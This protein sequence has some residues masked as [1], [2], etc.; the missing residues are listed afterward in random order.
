[1]GP[2]LTNRRPPPDGRMT[3]ARAVTGY[4]IFLLLCTS[5]AAVWLAVRVRG[6]HKALVDLHNNERER[7]FDLSLDMMCVA[8]FDGSVK[9]ANPQFAIATGWSPEEVLTDDF[10]QFIHPEDRELSAKLMM[11]AM[12]GEPLVNFRNRVRCKDGSYKLLAWKIAPDVK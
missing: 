8:G 3:A 10:I 7:L 12:A 5:A 4:L 1:R 6:Q 11:R 9:I 2:N